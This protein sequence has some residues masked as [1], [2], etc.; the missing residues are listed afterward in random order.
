MSRFVVHEHRAPRLHWD[1]RLEHGG[2]LVSWAVPKGVPLE[3]GINRLAVSVPDHELEHLTYTDADK[4]IWDLGTYTEHEFT[5]AKV[6]VTFDGERLH[7]SYAL[8]RT[9]SPQ[10]LLRRVGDRAGSGSVTA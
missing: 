8:I 2:V 10:W 4:S 1:L 6:V 3:P 9:S 7:G 5:D